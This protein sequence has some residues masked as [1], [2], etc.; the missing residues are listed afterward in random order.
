[1]LLVNLLVIL[2]L[3]L[4]LLTGVAKLEDGPEAGGA[5]QDVPALTLNHHDESSKPKVAFPQ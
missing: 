2:V 3:L 1:M 4:L 5:A